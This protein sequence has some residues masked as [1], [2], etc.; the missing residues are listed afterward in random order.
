MK[1][2]TYTEEN[3]F[4]Y[5]PFL[6]V[7]VGIFFLPFN[8]YEGIP[9]LREFARDSCLLFFF[10]A[11]VVQIVEVLISSKIVIPYNHPVILILLGLLSWFLLTYLLNIIDI[12]GY[13]MKK[14]S[15]HSRFISQYGALLISAGILFFTYYNAFRRFSSITVFKAIRKILFYSF[16]IV[17]VYTVIEILIIYFKLRFLQPV[18]YI[19]DYFPFCEAW[20]D[21]RHNRISSVTFEP[22]AFATY[23]ITIAG[24]MFSFL[25]TH[26]GVKSF[27]PSIMV[28]AFAFF[29]G[30]RSGLVIIIIQFLVFLLYFI[31]RRHY[32]KYIVRGLIIISIAS[33]PVLIY[34]GRVI[35]NFVYEK[36]TSFNLDDDQHKFSNQSRFGIIY[37]SGLIFLENPVVGVGFGQQA[38]E[39]RDMYPSW[40]TKNNWEFDYKYKNDNVK[41]FPP[42]YNIYTRLLAETGII[43]FS[44]FIIIIFSC[45]YICYQYMKRTSDK[46]IFFIILLVSFVGF[47]MDWFK[48]DT[49]RNYGFWISLA[50]LI[51]LTKNLKLKKQ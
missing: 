19:F 5:L 8:S 18:L 7:S 31:K 20:L 17:S 35:S 43:G 15:G 42:G 3:P 10:M 38:F 50:L 13:Y 51:L 1:S 24:W 22:P 33:L 16:L 44:I 37:T 21:Y 23:L 45:C 40:A 25:I 26:K 32:H 4:K 29:S 49:F 30:S 47:I 41:R 12:N 14:T 9:F 46:A 27:I 39:A 2:I 11:F 36:L 6:L 34:Q 48:S 28:I